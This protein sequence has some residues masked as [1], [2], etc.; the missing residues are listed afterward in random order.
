MRPII[1]PIHCHKII[2]DAKDELRMA[3]VSGY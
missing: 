3:G 2:E 1:V